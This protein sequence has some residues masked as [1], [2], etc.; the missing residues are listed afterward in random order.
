MSQRPLDPQWRPV[1]CLSLQ[2]L[3]LVWQDETAHREQGLEWLNFDSR[4]H[5][6]FTE[7]GHYPLRVV[8]SAHVPEQS[9]SSGF[10]ILDFDLSQI[11]LLLQADLG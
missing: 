6:H 2:R 8:D 11:P 4:S 3:W 1:V 9:Q 10:L 7:L 5:F